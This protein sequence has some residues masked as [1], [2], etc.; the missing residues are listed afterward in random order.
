MLA[1]EFPNI[2][3]GN[4]YT[5]IDTYTNT[6]STQ[7]P[8]NTPSWPNGAQN[9]PGAFYLL[10]QGAPEGPAT[11]YPSASGSLS[12]K[13]YGAPLVVRYVRYNST[14]NPNLL[15]YPAPVYWVDETFTTVSGVFSEG[16]PAGT[17]NLN[18]LAGLLLPN[19]TSLN[20]TA[21]AAAT[22]LNG[23]WCWIVTKGF[24]PSV[25][26]PSGTGVGDALT[27]TSGNF[28]LTRTGSGA[29]PISLRCFIAQTA[30]AA[31]V[32]DV[33]VNTEIF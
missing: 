12:S 29:A 20:E 11:A 2:S 1:A 10:S 7:P 4:L 21:A 13:G 18:S 9:P 17:G 19:Y 22:T 15:A 28:T 30:I 23:N 5:A 33:L 24:V 6:I 8:T 3:T 32:A 26:V 25:Y 31:G 27:G 16:N 14:G